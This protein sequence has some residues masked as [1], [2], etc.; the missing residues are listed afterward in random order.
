MSTQ[1]ENNPSGSHISSYV[2]IGSLYLVSVGVLYLWGYWSYFGID[3]LV[4]MNFTDVLKLT[5]YPLISS[6]V[7]VA[8]GA[9]LGES[10]WSPMF[11]PGGGRDSAVG[12]LLHRLL[13][14]LAI[15]YTMGTLAILVFG[16][17]TKWRILLPVLFA[18]PVAYQAKRR[19][20]LSL[21]LPNDSAR[22]VVILLLAVMPTFAYGQGK[23]KAAAVLDGSDYS[24]LT[25]STVEGLTV[26]DP[27]NP[28]NRIKYLGQVNDYVFLLLPDNETSVVVRFDKTHGL[29]LRRSR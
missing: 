17:V 23:L 20:M 7:F 4:Y 27:S 28:K 9:L 16:P 21:L 18:V 13:P 24:Y 26:S 2:Y 14:Y 6:A 19:G 10:V 8:I 3:V 15:A 29:Q 12:R 11:P 1:G 25:A 22:S 5:A